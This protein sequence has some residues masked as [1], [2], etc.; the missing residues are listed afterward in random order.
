MTVQAFVS[1]VNLATQALSGLSV[2]TE[3]ATFTGQNARY[4]EQPFMPWRTTAMVQQGFG[5]L[6]FGEYSFGGPVSG[7]APDTDLI[8]DFGSLQP[9]DC[10]LIVNTNYT[11]VSVSLDVTGDWGSPDWSA[12]LTAGRNPWTGRYAASALIQP[13]VNARYALVRISGATTDGAAYRSTGG[14]WWGADGQF[15]PR[16]IRWQEKMLTLEPVMDTPLPWGPIHRR[17]IG[18]PYTRIVAQRPALI[19]ATTPGLGDELATWLTI[20][21]NAEIFGSLT[22]FAN[23]GNPAEAWI[24]RRVNEPAWSIAHVVTEDALVLEEL[25]AP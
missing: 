24:M 21:R 6:A 8:M 4:P 22:W 15:V 14:V 7:I 12:A 9:V 10:V 16:D 13:A 18:Q 23:R 3:D 20:D 11:T 19:N 17:R 1:P 5:T 2:T 25:V